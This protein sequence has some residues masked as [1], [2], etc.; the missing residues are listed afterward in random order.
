MAPNPLVKSVFSHSHRSENVSLRTRTVLPGR[1]LH[2]AMAILAFLSLLPGCKSIEEYFS[3]LHA[4][5]GLERTEL[6]MYTRKSDPEILYSG[7]PSSQ[8]FFREH[9]DALSVDR[10]FLALTTVP[11]RPPFLEGGLWNYMRLSVNLSYP[12]TYRG[13]LLNYPDDGRTSLNPGETLLYD[14][15]PLPD[16][17]SR[18][19]EFL[20]REFRASFTV[21]F[22]Y[23]QGDGWYIATGWS[24]G[25]TRYDFDL[26]EGN[27][28]LASVRGQ[29][30]PVY[31]A[32]QTFAYDIG[33]HLDSDFWKD[34]YLFLELG[35]DL[36]TVHPIAFSLPRSN[37]LPA[38]RLYASTSYARFGIRK[39]LYLSGSPSPESQPR[40]DRSERPAKTRE[41]Q[42]REDAEKEEQKKSPPEEKPSRDRPK[43]EA[44]SDSYFPY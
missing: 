38:D 22:P 15:Y 35:T 29:W 13:S 31:M 20:Y 25:Q 41:N 11:A 24:I 34:T 28:R 32:S 43:R 17:I 5:A 30:T 12:R 16:A 9:G 40:Q 10:G 1:R 39:S 26:L 4:S 23:F 6:S 36:K 18:R 8:R 7:D 27:T 19:T 14:L 3:T 44:P 42:N 2:W 37:G 33:Q 21:F